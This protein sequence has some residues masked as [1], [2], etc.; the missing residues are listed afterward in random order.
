VTVL[1]RDEVERQAE[2]SLLIQR[3]EADLDR[4]CAEFAVLGEQANEAHARS[5]FDEYGARMAAGTRAA[6]I[7]DFRVFLH[8]LVEQLHLDPVAATLFVTRLQQDPATWRYM[9][10]GMVAAFGK[11][12]LLVGYAV[13]TTNRALSTLRQFARLAMQAQ[14]MPVEQSERIQRVQGYNEQE[15]ERLRQQDL[16]GTERRKQS[17]KPRATVMTVEQA[18]ALKHQHP[19]TLLGQRNRL[20]MCILLDL[21]LRISEALGIQCADIAGDL[22]TVCREKV[23]IT[24]VHRLKADAFAA[25]TAYRQAG[26]PTEGPL[27]RQVRRGDHLGAPLSANGAYKIV[28]ALGSQI[29]PP[30]ADLGPHDCRHSCPAGSRMW[31]LGRRMKSTFATGRLLSPC[32]LVHGRKRGN[33]VVPLGGRG[34]ISRHG[35]MPRL[36]LCPLVSI[37]NAP[38]RMAS[39]TCS[40]QWLCTESRTCAKSG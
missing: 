32:I 33:S 30:L 35:G 38:S 28:R 36:P 37:Q 31:P 18:R 40:W 5:V 1:R 15:A 26:G 14:Q 10:A 24:Q 16:A 12:M 23:G 39:F 22:V 27:I 2:T 11:W 3:V 9:H 4:F 34:S 29:A 21:G 7:D 17:R 8:F 19:A 13:S 25:L 6:Y 20:L